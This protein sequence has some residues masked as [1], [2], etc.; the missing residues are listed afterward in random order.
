MLGL[1]IVVVVVVVVVYWE[2]STGLKASLQ[3]ARDIS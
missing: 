3:G 2:T 1:V